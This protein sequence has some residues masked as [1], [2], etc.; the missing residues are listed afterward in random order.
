MKTIPGTDLLGFQSNPDELIYT[1]PFLETV[2]TRAYNI[3]LYTK[4]LLPVAG[5]A[6]SILC[7]SKMILQVARR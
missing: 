5:E 4:C 3:V 7:G 1:I 2:K 6:L